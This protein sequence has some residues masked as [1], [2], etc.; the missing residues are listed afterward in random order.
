[1]YDFLPLILVLYFAVPFRWKNLILLAGS[2]VFYAWGEKTLVLMLIGTIILGWL[3][4]LLIEKCRG[5]KAAAWWMW[6]SVLIDLGLLGYYK[7]TDFVLDS[8]NHV[9]RTSIP[10]LQIALP[11]GIS[12]YTFQILSYTV[13]V[14]RGTV[15]AQ[16]NLIDFAAY[17]SLFPQLIAGPIVRYAD[18]EKQLKER[19][20]SLAGAAE[21]MRRLI[22]GLGKKVLI[23]NTMG[24]LC[25]NFRASSDLSVL[26]FWMYAAAFMLQIYYDFSGYSDM[27]IGLGKIFGFSFLENFRYPYVAV[28]IT[29]FW[30]RWHI[31][32]GTWFRDYVYIPLGGNRRGIRRQLIN[33]LVVWGLTGLWHGASWN[34]VLWGL[35]Y[36]V[37]LMIE[38][39]GLLP[40][41]E[42]HRYIGHVYTI[43]MVM[44]G[45]VLF[46]ADDL[47]Q[48]RTDFLGLSGMLD[49]PLCS[50]EA[51][52]MLRSN[53]RIFLAGMI[54]ATPLPGRICGIITG[55]GKN[56]S[57]IRQTAESVYLVLILLAVTAYLVDGSFNPFLYFR[58]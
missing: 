38:K 13:D 12:F 42:R 25:A 19:E 23:A 37:L 29:E 48:A 24:E 45:F 47:A 9:L 57:R 51:W 11:I 55:N 8:V 44:F 56:D 14:W 40:W 4:G 49:I 36:A 33:I 39:L 22:L 35:L 26:Y 10:L 6:I 20:H 34:F 7:Y 2:L 3:F 27:A 18:V 53:W 32:L 16:T 46:H 30:R 31:S 1:M 5:S 21:G 54:G 52:Y 41:L 15:R 43:L 17:V 58:F 28:S 50:V